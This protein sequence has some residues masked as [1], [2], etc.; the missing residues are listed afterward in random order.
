M[1][2]MTK[3]IADDHISMDNFTPMTR[4]SNAHIAED[5][6][7][8]IQLPSIMSL[9]VTTPP[10]LTVESTMKAPLQGRKRYLEE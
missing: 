4:S 7:T 1:I 6:E 8:A 5:H 9:T 10:V 2:G 3:P